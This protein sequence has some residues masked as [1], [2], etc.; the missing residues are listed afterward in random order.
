[1][2]NLMSIVYWETPPHTTF[3]LIQHYLLKELP[4]LLG[5]VWDLC[6]YQWLIYMWVYWWNL[7]F[8]LKWYKCQ[9]VWYWLTVLGCALRR[10]FHLF[11]FWW[12]FL[13]L[14]IVSSCAWTDQYSSEHSKGKSLM[15]SRSFFLIGLSLCSIF[16]STQ[17]LSV[18]LWICN[19]FLN[20]T[21]LLALV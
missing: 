2:P 20:S 19:S 21:R 3:Q 12:F 14:P 1:M 11:S 4:F 15:I 16:P 6:H 10:I 7:F 17:P 5:I 13:Q 9:T 8:L 18:P